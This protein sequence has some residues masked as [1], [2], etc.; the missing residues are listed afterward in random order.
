M[1]MGNFEL[2]IRLTTVRKDAGQLAGGPKGEFSQSLLRI[3]FATSPDP[4]RNLFNI[5]MY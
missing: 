5:V 3:S 1:N 2:E 4:K